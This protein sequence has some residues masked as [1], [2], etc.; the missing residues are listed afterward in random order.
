MAVDGQ[1][2]AFD[3][4]A[5]RDDAVAEFHLR[6]ALEL[7]LWWRLAPVR[8][9]VEQSIAIAI[10]A[11]HTAIE[12]L[13]GVSPEVSKRIASTSHW[14]SSLATSASLN[15]ATDLTYAKPHF[16]AALARPRAPAGNSGDECDLG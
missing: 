10:L 13:L 14:S 12:Y 4:G 7:A 9:S 6:H 1:T 16:I 8:T 2:I 11:G 15:G 5:L 3:Q